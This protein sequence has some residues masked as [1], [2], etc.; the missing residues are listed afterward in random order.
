MTLLSKIGDAGEI[1]AQAIL[2]AH[3][4]RSDMMPRNNPGFDLLTPCGA[5]VQV[6]TR[7]QARGMGRCVTV[8][9]WDFDHLFVRLAP[10]NKEPENY[11]IPRA[12]LDRIAWKQYRRGY[13]VRLSKIANL[14]S[15]KLTEI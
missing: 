14:H 4:V 10:P 2:N 5:R 6:K 15:Y 12:L 13:T 7:A 11:C 3:G 9:N 8:K 1:A